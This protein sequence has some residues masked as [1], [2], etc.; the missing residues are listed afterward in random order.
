M[1]RSL[2][3]LR[4][5]FQYELLMQVRRPSLWITFLLV[6]VFVLR[7]FDGLYLSDQIPTGATALG[8]WSGF[9]A[10]FYP[11]AGGLLLADR[12]P[13]DQ[14]YHVTELLVTTPSGLGARLWGKYAGAT[15]AT[16]I[17]V[18]ALYL[19]GALLIMQYHHDF[20]ALPL[21][22]AL[23][24]ANMGTAV[25]FVGAFS[26]ACTTVIWP[27]LYQFLF[28]GYWFWGNFLNPKLGIPTLNGTLLTP[29]GHS[30]IAGLFPSTVLT[31]P[32]FHGA[33]ATAAQGIGS[34]ALLLGCAFLAQLAT[35]GWLRWRQQHQ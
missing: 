7:T 25:L 11:L 14:K 33:T 32:G 19:G 5:T 6:S 29:S 21:A 26:I 28:V 1:M 22:L 35:W 10:L 3:A 4:G 12:F 27:T 30:I 23:F 31:R 9:L 8:S 15:V 24:V 34:L 17:P 13:R 2:A 20:A 18:L 16:L